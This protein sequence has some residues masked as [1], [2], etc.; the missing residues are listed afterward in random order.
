MNSELQRLKQH[1][2]FFYGYLFLLVAASVWLFI[3][4]KDNCFLFINQY[5]RPWLDYF[6]IGYTY[7]GNGLVI[8]L[9]VL[10]L[11]FVLKKRKLA[12]TLLIAF[13]STGILT[14]II[15]PLVHSPRP[16]NY[17]YP[18]RLSFFIDDVILAGDN[19]FPSGH[20]ATAFA[21]AAVLALYTNKKWHHF[22]LLCAA[23][24]VGFSRIFLSQHFLLDVLMGS[25]IGVM[26]GL[27]TLYFCRNLDENKLVF[28]KK[29]SAGN[30]NADAVIEK[31]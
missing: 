6:F 23:V 8:I 10:I 17:F 3:N 11:F 29:Q 16:E 21:V 18:Q 12:V 25:F 31:L 5:H 26:G 22:L 4:G 27:L 28:K 9:L 13:S 1:T 24:L 7:M 20:T 15:K 30:E 2:R 19:S 14:Q